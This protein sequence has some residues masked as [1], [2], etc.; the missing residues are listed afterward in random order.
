MFDIGNNPR[1]KAGR[2]LRA[3][4]PGKPPPPPSFSL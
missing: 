2:L 4:L 1:S 3:V